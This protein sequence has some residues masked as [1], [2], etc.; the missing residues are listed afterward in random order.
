M[1]IAPNS[2]KLQTI[3]LA[4][5]PNSFRI[6]VF[7]LSLFFSLF[8]GAALAFLASY[9]LFMSLTFSSLSSSVL[10]CLVRYRNTFRLANSHSPAFR[11]P[12]C[13]YFLTSSLS[14]PFLLSLVSSSLGLLS[15]TFNLLQSHGHLLAHIYLRAPTCSKRCAVVAFRFATAK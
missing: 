1:K 15:L 10:Q 8:S 2:A 11:F 5:S 4:P 9:L 6:S 14:S 7:S 3:Y 13:S 12:A